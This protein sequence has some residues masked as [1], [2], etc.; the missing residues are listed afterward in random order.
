MRRAPRIDPQLDQLTAAGCRNGGGLGSS[1]NRRLVSTRTALTM[2]F[3]VL[4]ALVA[5][6]TV[7]PPAAHAAPPRYKCMILPGTNYAFGLNKLG[8]VVGYTNQFGG[9]AFY[10]KAGQLTSFGQITI[11]YAISDDG[12][13]AGV[14]EVD[15]TTHTARAMM[16][17]RAGNVTVMEDGGAQGS[18]ALAINNARQ[19]VGYTD[20]NDGW[21]RAA[22]WDAGA[23]RDISG[24]HDRNSIAFAINNLGTIVGADNNRAA[25]FDL[26]P[27]DMGA[28]G[29]SSAARS[30]SDSGYVAGGST[31]ND[32]SGSA[33]V[34]DGSGFQIIATGLRGSTRAI[35]V[36]NLGQ[37]VGT[38]NNEAFLWDEGTYYSLA[39][40][41]DEGACAPYEPYSIN[42]CGVIVG[43]A[44]V[45]SPALGG[46]MMVPID[47]TDDMDT[48]GDGLKDR[49]ERCGLD[50]DADGVAEFVPPEANPYHADLYVELDHVATAP[51]RPEVQGALVNAFAQVPEADLPRLNPDRKPGITLHLL[52]D[53]TSVDLQG[54]LSIG[55]APYHFPAEFD[56]IR[57]LFFGTEA[58]RNDPDKEKILNAKHQVY[59]Y[60]LMV[61]GLTMTDANG[62]DDYMTGIGECPGNDF[63]IAT[64]AFRFPPGSWQEQAGALMHELGH[65]LGL[66][67]GGNDD[68]NY[69]VNYFSIMNYAWVIPHPGQSLDWRLDYSR[70]DPSNPPVFERVLEEEKGLAGITRDGVS[71]LVYIAVIGQDGKPTGVRLVGTDVPNVDFN[72]N[73]RIDAGTVDVDINYIDPDEPPSPHDGHTDYNDWR[74]IKLDFRGSPSFPA[75]VHHLACLG[76]GAPELSSSLIQQLAAVVPENPA[77]IAVLEPARQAAPPAGSGAGPQRTDDLTRVR[78]TLP[79]AGPVRVRVFDASGRL[80]RTLFD[81]V[82]GAG[83]LEM[84]WDGRDSRGAQV[85]TGLYFARI[86]DAQGRRTTRIIVRR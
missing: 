29:E 83:P 66:K 37:V 64:K 40:L 21:N 55:A 41:I 82:Q 30:I 8:E 57:E 43:S 72:S 58:E 44:V 48:D 5:G 53:D 56:D 77:N 86:E 85:G 27:S 79:E 24:G 9:P 12:H 23:F 11:A 49:W 14:H 3:A 81:D 73:G 46:F 50:L 32:G 39:S 45:G 80:V 25:Y 60:G 13:I 74:N 22:V 78:F 65:N 35:S 70:P 67:H 19:A 69:K 6:P 31:N 59:R 2:A 68:T 34:Y 20:G 75:G 71:V 1:R 18:E 28:P 51:I 42:D 63:I 84:D 4:V 52:V 17:D 15:A 7:T 38:A 36:N 61:E 10:Y 62:S 54:N 76:S 26:A 47:A 33:W 16:A